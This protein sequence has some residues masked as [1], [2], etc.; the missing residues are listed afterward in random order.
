MAMEIKL[1]EL[2]ENIE[3]GDVVRVLVSPG[4]TVEMDQPLLEVETGKAT[5]E[6]PAESAGTVKE[7]RVAEG[8]SV[9]VGQLV[10]VLDPVGGGEDEA[11]SSETAEPDRSDE[12][13]PAAEAGEQAAEETAPRPEETKKEQ[14]QEPPRE[15][16]PPPAS[17]TASS[18]S[19][20]HVPVLAAPSVRQFARGIGVV[21]EDVTGSGARGRI[22]EK[23][24][25]AHAKR[26]N[27]S[28]G[29]A[30]PPTATP[31]PDF[32]RFGSVRAESMSAVR[33][34]TM[35]HMALAWATVPHVTQH[36]SADITEM[37]ELR[38]RFADK[39]EKAGGKL[40]VTAIL[41]KI[42]AAA[43]KVHPKF[44]ASIDP[45]KQEVVFKDY[46]HI[47]VAV[48][49]PKGL[50]VPVLRDVD[51]KNI[52]ELSVELG[53]LAR[54]ARDGKIKP[55]ELEGGSFTLTNVGGI[56]GTYF[57]PIVNVPEV[58]ILGVGRSMKMPACGREDGLCRPRHMLPL[59]L[60]YDHR[61]IDGAD[62]ARFIRWV[63][64]AIEEPLLI[65][66]EG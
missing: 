57:T 61:L 7:V 45:A 48:D 63:V 36:D 3:G 65:S 42:V 53:D 37:D 13:E 22:T 30:A 9:K 15:S 58:A 25:K 52:V 46:T 26:L 54:R 31:L 49:T 12:S 8:D 4:D 32:S 64:E 23:D 40:T 14:K 10:V 56:G 35:K 41:I 33:K 5:L 34:A 11:E 38:Q 44:N 59:S 28:R 50:L 62:G 19:P 51:R 16:S 29:E 43:L 60:S 55:G 24:V 6:V 47:G 39:A 27:E 17:G 18:K 1:P 21:I 2:G 20:D 66:L